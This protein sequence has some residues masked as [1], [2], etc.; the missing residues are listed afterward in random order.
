MAHFLPSW[1]KFYCVLAR[2][3]YKIVKWLGI[4]LVGGNLINGHWCSV[5]VQAVLEAENCHGA[6][7]LLRAT[8]RVRVQ[9]SLQICLKCRSKSKKCDKP[10]NYTVRVS[11]S[12]ILFYDFESRVFCF[13]FYPV[14]GTRGFAPNLMSKIAVIDSFIFV[15]NSINFCKF[16]GHRLS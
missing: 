16:I 5:A 12:G 8:A 3:R 9:R 13:S 4:C 14:N 7:F 1:Y 15:A 2:S 10:I 11:F 6:G